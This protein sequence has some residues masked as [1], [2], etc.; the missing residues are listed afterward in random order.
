MACP[1]SPK[2]EPHKHDRMAECVLKLESKLLES[3]PNETAADQ[4]WNHITRQIPAGDPES[5]RVYYECYFEMMYV[6]AKRLTA[7]DEQSCLDIVQDSMLKVVRSIKQIADK[8][9]LDAWT[10]SVVR[11]VAYDSLR[12]Q[13]KQQ[14][15]RAKYVDHSS[16]AIDSDHVENEA[17]LLWIQEQLQCVEPDIRRM[18]TLRYRFGWSLAKIAGKFGIK[19]GAVDGRIRRALENLKTRAKLEFNE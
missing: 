6:E 15:R 16:A 14:A 7:L 12:K 5:F 18:I 10:R 1:H 4:D 8:S 19:T 3:M 13:Q 9:H 17:R 2:L 11:S